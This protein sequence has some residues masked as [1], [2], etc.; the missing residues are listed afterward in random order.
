MNWFERLCRNTGLMLHHVAQPTPRP[1]KRE[2]HRTTQ[3]QQVTPD[4]TLRRTTID[5]IE[6]RPQPPIPNP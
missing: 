4:V 5:E 2:I 1:A 6:I 3:Q